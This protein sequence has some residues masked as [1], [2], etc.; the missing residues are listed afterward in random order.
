MC[1][2]P[3]K[4]GK[5]HTKSSATVNETPGVQQEHAEHGHLQ[6]PEWSYSVPHVFV[7]PSGSC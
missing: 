7:F 1:S 4:G 6:C 2:L 3:I 5:M